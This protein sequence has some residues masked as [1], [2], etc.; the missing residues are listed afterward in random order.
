M[1]GSETDSASHVNGSQAET[2]HIAESR[3]RAPLTRRKFIKMS[4]VALASAVPA[5]L[6]K[7]AADHLGRLRSGEGRVNLPV[8]NTTDVS[9][10]EGPELVPLMPVP[11]IQSGAAA[12]NYPPG[13]NAH[14]DAVVN[15][16]LTPE[17]PPGLRINP[18][19]GREF[20]DR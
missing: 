18:V 10:P 4:F 3:V 5:L 20:F 15:R 16:S 7:T 9:S 19:D 6:I 13:F 1:N 14:T 11:V 12:P 17:D 8:S 2:S